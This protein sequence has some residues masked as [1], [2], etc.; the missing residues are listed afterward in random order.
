MKPTQSLLAGNSSTIRY[1]VTRN[2]L[3][4][5][6]NAEEKQNALHDYNISK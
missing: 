1:H 2:K 5:M 4:K 6:R 3:M